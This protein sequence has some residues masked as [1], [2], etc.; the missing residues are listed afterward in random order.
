MKMHLS[1][2]IPLLVLCGSLSTDAVP[3]A[4]KLYKSFVKKHVYA[5][6]NANMCHDVMEKKSKEFESYPKPVNTFITNPGDRI[7][8]FCNNKGN[9][10]IQSSSNDYNIVTCRWDNSMNRYIGYQNTNVF[11]KLHCLHG[12]PVHF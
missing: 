9:G 7:K 6:M 10:L 11:I 4:G 1:A 8:N 5:G 12:V 2:V 3:D